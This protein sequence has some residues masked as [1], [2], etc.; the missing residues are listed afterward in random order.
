MDGQS[1]HPSSLSEKGRNADL[2]NKKKLE[3]CHSKW[4]AVHGMHTTQR[5]AHYGV[6]TYHLPLTTYHH[7]SHMI[8]PPT[9]HT[10]TTKWKLHALAKSFGTGGSVLTDF[11]GIRIL[12]YSDCLLSSEVQKEDPKIIIIIRR[13]VHWLVLA[14]A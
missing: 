1:L 11:G 10:T 8:Q 4:W 12:N 5:I 14:Y 3:S 13:N 7:P 9:L 2:I 6:T